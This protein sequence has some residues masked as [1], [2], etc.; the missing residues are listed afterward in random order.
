[1][2]YDFDERK[3]WSE[4]CAKNQSISDIL[5]AN[6]PGFLSVKKA[7]DN[8][9]RHGTDWW[10]NLSNG[11]RLSID[12]KAREMDW[13]LRGEDD[14][15]LET[16]SVVGEKVG[17]TLDEQKRTDYILWHW[18]ETGRWCLVPFRMLCK[19]FREHHDKWVGRYKTDKQT[20]VRGERKWQSECVF[21]PRGVVWG[22]IY[23]KFGGK[24]CSVTKT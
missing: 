8:E 15:A 10:V 21:V 24:P 7:T 3:Q 18:E 19:I 17:W 22:A 2:Q 23:L 6:V 1:M 13:A 9:D 5:K 11:Q 14:L 4:G 16:W 12:V 20:T